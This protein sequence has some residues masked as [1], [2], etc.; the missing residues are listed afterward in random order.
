MIKSIGFDSPFH[1]SLLDCKACLSVTTKLLF[2][3]YMQVMGT[4][5]LML[6][7]YEEFE[8]VFTNIIPYVVFVYKCA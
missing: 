6:V 8:Q 4:R 1:T 3:M 2:V 7:T 5:K